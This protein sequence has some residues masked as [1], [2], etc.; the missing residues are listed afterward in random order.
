MKAYQK[1]FLD[2]MRKPQL[3]NDAFSVNIKR[4]FSDALGKIIDKSTLPLILQS[5]LPFFLWQKFD[6]TGGFKIARS[7]TPP[8]PWTFL[9]SYEYGTS[10]DYF[11]FSGFNNV[12]EKFK[13]GDLVAVYGDDPVNINKLA[14]VV[15]S[16]PYQ[17]Y[18]SMLHNSAINV[19]E[20]LYFCDNQANYNEALH[21]LQTN[22]IG[23]FTDDQ[24]Q[25]LSYKTTDTILNDFILLK[26][27]FRISK[28]IGFY[29]YFNFNTESIIFTFKIKL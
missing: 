6:K 16:S 14:W 3:K 4:Y 15:I 22:D 24:F 11:Q 18:T 27:N 25:P 20:F 7:I 17:A 19:Y 23:L 9:Y 8:A 10:F 12:N 28:H 5:S 2:E 1:N 21:F 29:G 26:L 13:P